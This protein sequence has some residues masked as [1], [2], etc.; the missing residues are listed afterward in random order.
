MPSMT[1]ARNLF[2]A[3]AVFVPSM[4]LALGEPG[5]LES[6]ELKSGCEKMFSIEGAAWFV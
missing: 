1:S 2:D 4:M 3:S 5:V 6:G